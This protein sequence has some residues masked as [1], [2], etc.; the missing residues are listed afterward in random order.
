MANLPKARSILIAVP[1]TGGVMKSK[2]A[3]SLM[4]L[5]KILTARGINADVRNIDN[6][7]VVTVRNIYANTLLKSDRWDSLLFIDS[8]M[9]FVPRAIA[10][11]I[12][13]NGLVAGMA[14]TTRNLDLDKFAKAVQDHGDVER[15]RAESSRFNVLKTWDNTKPTLLKHKDGFYTMAAVGMAV[16]LIR[17]AALEAMIAE[18]VV[19]QRV[20]I[21][22]SVRTTSWGFFDHLKH[23]EVTLLEDFSFC[24]RWT[25]KMGRPLWVCVDEEIKHIG[26]FA[27]GANYAPILGSFIQQK[28]SA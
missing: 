11:M 20:D 8:D 14:C 24:Y 12:D 7:D 18:G 17:K 3:E 27:Y 28:E 4:Q 9:Q 10:R 23:G 22:D 21:Y 26:E 25:M 13:L 16:C 2:T 19:E 5:M 1:T 6:S 15:A